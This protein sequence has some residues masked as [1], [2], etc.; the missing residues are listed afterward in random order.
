MDN[1]KAYLMRLNHKAK[2]C[3]FYG[4]YNHKLY[5]RIIMDFQLPS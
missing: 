5:D 1:W 4:T 3:F 2:L